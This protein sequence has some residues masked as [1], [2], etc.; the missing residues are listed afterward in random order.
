MSSDPRPEI[1]LQP[2]EGW[3][4]SHYFYRFDRARLRSLGPSELSDGC[5]EFLAVLAPEGPLAPTRLQTFVIAGHKADFGL[6]A[7]DPDP[8]VIDSVHQRL[9]A[10]PLGSALV[11]AWS[12]VSITEVSEYIPSV[13]QYGERLAKEGLTAGTDEHQGKLKQ[14]ER[15]LEI[16]RRQR[17]TPD[18]PT[19][20]ALCFYPMNKKRAAAENWFR[21][22]FHER[23]R[24][25]AEH[26]ES[27]MKFAGKVT[28][29]VT[30]GIGL[31]DW[32]WGVTLWA[33]NPG[34]LS[35]IVYRMRFDEA[36]A[37]FGEFGPFY[38]GY[39]ATAAEILRHCRVGQ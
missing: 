24:L 12:Y 13:E 29:L 32:E 9:M 14:Y 5:S 15:R 4:C 21:L 36:S 20:P 7:M 11:A 23:E 33:R 18:L 6:L 19:W 39:L 3:H 38:I 30:V 27:G 26:G 35:Q 25:M 31:D 37:R 17:L 8:L 10:G 1:S 34:F 2:T 22:D 28:Q 16:M